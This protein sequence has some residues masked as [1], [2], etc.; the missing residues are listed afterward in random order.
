VHEAV[1]TVEHQWRCINFG[2]QS[3]EFPE[4]VSALHVGAH[5]NPHF[6]LQ[7]SHCGGWNQHDMVVR[8][9]QYYT[10]PTADPAS[11]DGQV[12][13]AAAAAAA[14][15]VRETYE[16]W[17]QETNESPAVL[18]SPHD[19]VAAVCDRLGIAKS[20]CTTFFPE[21][22]AAAHATKAGA[23]LGQTYCPGSDG[24][25]AGRT[26]PILQRALYLY[27]RDY[28]ALRFPYPQWMFKCFGVAYTDPSGAAHS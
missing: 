12:R 10:M 23:V 4:F 1:G 13:A 2:N 16:P 9:S 7:S 19:G 24:A 22:S 11:I 14:V 28:D 6:Q 27:L 3:V 20:T 17:P 21:T 5:T 18:T 26:S 8:W 15:D 25:S